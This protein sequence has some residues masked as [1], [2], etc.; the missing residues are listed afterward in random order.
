MGRSPR[1]V[2]H[3][4]VMVLAAA[5]LRCA[6]EAQSPSAS[7]NRPAF[8]TPHGPHR[9]PPDLP[10]HWH[11]NRDGARLTLS[12]AADPA[13]GALTGT[14]LSEAPG[15]TPDVIDSGFYA[16]GILRLHVVE[17][18]G[19]VHYRVRVADGVLAGRTSTSAQTPPN[20]STDYTGRVTG[21]RE[22][23]FDSAPR[24]W[25]V[26]LDGHTQAVLRIDRA[27]PDGA[28]RIGTLKPYALDGVLDEQPSEDVDVREWDGRLLS[29]VRRAAPGQPTYTA[30][31]VGRTLAGTTSL[32]DAAPAA[33][34]GT[35]MEVLTHGLGLRTAAE[36]AEW[37]SRTRR[38]L[39]LLALGGNPAP[40]DMQVADLGTSAPSPDLA[41]WDRDDDVASWPP[42]YALHELTF[43]S[44][45]P[46]LAGGEAAPRHAHGF[47]AVPTSPA[48]PGGY[49]V[50]LA[51]NGHGG[52]ARDVFDPLGL[53]WYGDSLARR[54]YVVVA[55]DVGHRPLAD[56]ASVYDGYAT[57]DD[58]ATGNGLHPAIEASG[59]S[60]DW[61]EDGERAWDAMR[62]LD[63]AL[64][65]PDVNPAAVVAAG[66]SMGGEITDWVGAMDPRIGAVV[67]AGSP[68]DLAVMR[69]HGNHPCWEWQRGDVREYLD[70][71]DL[72]ALVAP[73]TA[74]R[75][76]GLADTVYSSAPAPF[77]IAKEVVRR[78][79][80]TFEAAGGRLIHYLHFDG[81]AFHAGQFCPVEGSADGVTAPE[82]AGPT[83]ADPWATGWAADP[84][85]TPIAPS[86]YAFLPG[87]GA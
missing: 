85:R 31:A 74:I 82:V 39:A 49:P 41:G 72:D 21:W 45:V 4:Y 55:I 52:S 57:G 75:E 40:L 32:G 46:A 7:P 50:A 87:G 77:A 34:G 23:T 42:N 79:E 65:R 17:P 27:T 19:P 51:L 53:Y 59:M 83:A 73:R 81:H 80:P 8:S 26:S 16:Q 1:V 47:L 14:S 44:R 20:E 68:A 36:V 29:F 54:G 24:V 10:G 48:P 61:E 33:W 5:A 69:L 22:E 64:G 11:L 43:D 28:A 60:S 66:L 13:T 3:L 30:T 78:A 18:T 6:D 38:R 67:S 25:D 71:G 86:I 70:P 9:V 15:A 84:D 76:T 58:P 62:G 56:R 37:Q 35:R 63:Y 12:I 2:R